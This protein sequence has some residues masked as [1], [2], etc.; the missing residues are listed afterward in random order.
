[1]KR[2]LLFG[3]FLVF[4]FASKAQETPKNAVKINPL[5]LIFATG[6]VSYEHATGANQ[7]FQIGA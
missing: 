4:A 2:I 7:S 5:S 3:A 1:M 6:N